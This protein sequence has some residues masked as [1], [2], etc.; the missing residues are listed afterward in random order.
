[1]ASVL[2]ITDWDSRRDVGDLVFGEQVEVAVEAHEL[3]IEIGFAL[4][5]AAD[6]FVAFGE[7]DWLRGVGG[8]EVGA[9]ELFVAAVPA[10]AAS[11]RLRE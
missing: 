2:G 3:E 7:G 6:C 5:D 8:A 1:M 11:G 4:E 10:A 9:V